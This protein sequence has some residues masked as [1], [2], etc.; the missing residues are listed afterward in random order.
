MELISHKNSSK[1]RSQKQRT[2]L[3]ERERRG[4]KKKKRKASGLLPYLPLEPHRASMPASPL[5]G[6]V[7]YGIPMFLPNSAGLVINAADD[8]L[9]VHF[10]GA[11]GKDRPSPCSVASTPHFISLSCICSVM[12]LQKALSLGSMQVG[13]RKSPPSR[14][15]L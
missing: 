13:S 4:K 8:C 1:G 7:E 9:A 10:Q 12:Q 15:E 6:G 3:G 5:L 14:E 2:R 11:R